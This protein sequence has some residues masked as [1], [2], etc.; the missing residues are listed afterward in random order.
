[1]DKVDGNDTTKKLKGAIFQLYRIGGDGTKYYA[2]V[3]T[4]GVLTGF[5]TDASLATNLTTDANGAFN[6][7]GLSSGTYHLLETKAP[8]GGYNKLADEIKV[9]ITAAA[10]ASTGA[11]TTFSGSVVGVGSAASDLP[12]GNVTL[13]VKNNLGTTLPETGGIGTA[14]FYVAGAALLIGA[15]VILAAK[16]RTAK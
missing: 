16:K 14:I 7:K 1:M 13:T 9:T 4:S 10:D 3:N 6:V 12:T 5:T 15:L 2:Q 11:L 8:D